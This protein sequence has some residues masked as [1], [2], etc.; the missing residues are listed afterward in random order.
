MNITEALEVTGKIR[1]SCWTP[2]LFAV[3]ISGTSFQVM[4]NVNGEE[5]PFASSLVLDDILA[6]DWEPVYDLGSTMSF[7]EVLEMLFS[8]EATIIKNTRTGAT[9]KQRSA[10]LYPTHGGDGCRG[11]SATIIT[12]ELVTARWVKVS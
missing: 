11:P 6:N 5:E 8:G 7:Q 2:H 10:V 3:Q 12:S 1:R 9:F 4:T